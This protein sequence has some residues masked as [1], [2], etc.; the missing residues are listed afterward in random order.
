MKVVGCSDFMINQKKK[1]TRNSE[2]EQNNIIKNSYV[3]FRYSKYHSQKIAEYYIKSQ[4][5]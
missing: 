3:L 1:T 2:E 4:M 5:K